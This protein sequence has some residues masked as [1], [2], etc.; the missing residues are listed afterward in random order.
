M[1]TP[2]R[3]RHLDVMAFLLT[4]CIGVWIGGGIVVGAVA[5]PTAFDPSVLP[6]DRA[7][8]YGV[9]LFP[10]LNL[11]EGVLGAIAVLLAAFLGRAGW[12]TARRHRIATGSVLLMT[13]IVVVF[14]LFLTPAIVAKTEQLRADGVDLSDRADMPPDR[15]LLGRLHGAYAGLD[16]LKLLSGVVVLWLLASRRRR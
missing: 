3:A 15:V 9:A 1:V 16:L 6:R 8:D 5:L 14:L 4:V 7:A 10:K 11:F 2:P 12:G 13:A